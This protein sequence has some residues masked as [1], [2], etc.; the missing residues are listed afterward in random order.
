M[1]NKKISL[2]LSNAE[3]LV[4]FEWLARSESE[5]SFAIKHSAEQQ[6]LWSI[7]GQLEKVLVEPLS[8]NYVELLEHARNEVSGNE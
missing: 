2:E 3:A 8:P 4:L 5:K 7:E 1:T 6:V